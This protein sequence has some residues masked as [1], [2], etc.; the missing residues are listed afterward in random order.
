MKEG[1]KVKSGQGYKHKRLLFSVVL[2]LLLCLFLSGCA[3]GHSAW[4]KE[5]VLLHDGQTIIVDRSQK[6][7][8]YRTL[9]APAY[10]R[11]V[12]EEKWDF[13]VPGTRKVVTWRV[14]QRFPPE[15]ES[16]ILIMV[17]FVQGTPYIATWPG[18]TIP[19]NYWGRPN[20]PYVF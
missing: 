6:L 10:A 18:G 17:G 9:D 19:Y 4:W 5:E 16:L 14:N 12:L 13:P 7:G 11:T 2:I 3:L 8:G 15:G 20:P 1:P